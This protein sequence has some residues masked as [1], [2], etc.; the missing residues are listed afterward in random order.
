VST[1]LEGNPPITRNYTNDILRSWIGVLTRQPEG[2]LG[3]PRLD[4]GWWYAVVQIFPGRFSG[5][6]T[7]VIMEVR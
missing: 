2:H 7:V 1:A 3:Q 4:R 6:T 5:L